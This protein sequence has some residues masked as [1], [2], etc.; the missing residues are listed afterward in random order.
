[1][2]DSKEITL[3]T[4]TALTIRELTARQLDQVLRTVNDE[5]ELDRLYRVIDDDV[6]AEFVAQSTGLDLE[7]QGQLSMEDLL[8]LVPAIKEVNARFLSHLTARASRAPGA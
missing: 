1:M 3:T 4:G 2:F 7:A 5:R 6:T 8:L